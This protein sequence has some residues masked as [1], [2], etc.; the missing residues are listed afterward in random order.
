MKE[1]AKVGKKWVDRLLSAWHL[2]GTRLD[3]TS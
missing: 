3:Q 2:A 1:V